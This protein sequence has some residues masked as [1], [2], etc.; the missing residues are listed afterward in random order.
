MSMRQLAEAIKPYIIE[1]RRF[2]HANPELSKMEVET[3]KHIVEELQSLGVEVQTF[4]DI[5]GCV[6]TIKGAS[7]GPTIMLRAD[8]DALPIQ[9]SN[10]VA[11]A[12]KNAGVMHACGHDCHTAMLLGAANLLMAQKD[13]IAGTIKLLFQMG[14]EV[15]TESRRYVER[16]VLQDVNAIFGMHI[17]SLLEAGTVNIDDGE[18]MACSDRFT[19]KVKGTSADIALPEQGADG[20]LAASAIVVAL[21]SLV[22]RYKTVEDT[23]V[24]SVCQMNGGNVV[25]SLADT[26]ELVGTTR[27]F[28][29]EL[30]EKLPTLIENIATQAASIYGCEVA[31]EYVFGPAP[32]INEHI[33]LNELARKAAATVMGEEALVP[34]IK[35]MG[36]EDFSVYLE[37]VPG[38]FA[39]LGARNKEKGICCVHHASNF[40]VDEDV[41]PSGS[42]LY[43]EFALQYLKQ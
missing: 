36:A 4:S 42:A 15:G 17:W 38:V 40:D 35:E 11:Y 19:I 32:L 30:R 6:G 29:R 43:A 18:R 41:L 33:P 1:Q 9:E 26:V 20:I 22:T 31:C 10:E 28:N 7:E 21:Q 14:E 5:T 25:D 2:L 8:I 13:K 12:S 16:G 3:T 24:V 37:H 34:M 27:A 23:L 39:F